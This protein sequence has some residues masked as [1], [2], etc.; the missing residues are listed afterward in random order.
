VF[1]ALEGALW[2]QQVLAVVSGLE[3]VSW[4]LLRLSKRCWA[5]PSIGC[6]HPGRQLFALRYLLAAVCGTTHLVRMAAAR[7]EAFK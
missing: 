3:S 6:G 7:Y 5:A 4:A 1:K 2:G